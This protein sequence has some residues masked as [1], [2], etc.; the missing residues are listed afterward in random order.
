MIGL[1]TIAAA[2]GAD[3][4]LGQIA[5]VEG[6]LAPG[7][8][9]TLQIAKSPIQ[10]T[11]RPPGAPP[12]TADLSDLRLAGARLLRT[13]A[14][15]RG[16]TDLEVIPDLDATAIEVRLGNERYRFPVRPRPTTPLGLPAR[17]R[18]VTLGDS[19]P[20]TITSTTTP[21]LSVDDLD[22]YASEG[23]VVVRASD[24]P[25][26]LEVQLTPERN[27]APRVVPLVVVDHRAAR[28]PE[29]VPVVLRSRPRLT[30]NA[31]PGSAVTLGIGRRTYGPVTMPPSGTLAMR[32]DQYPGET[33]AI[34][35][36]SDDLGNTST[37]ELPLATTS[38]PSL[39]IVPG[40]HWL[41]GDAPP[42][43]HVVVLLA[44]GAPWPGTPRCET[45]RDRVAVH[46]VRPGW[47]TL[48]LPNGGDFWRS[49]QRDLRIACTVGDVTRTA[50]VGVVPGVP[51]RLA[52]QVWPEDL[53]SDFPIAELR[54]GVEDGRGERVDVP[55]LTVTAEHGEV[56]ARETGGTL[57]GEYQGDRAIEFGVDEV[58][59]TYRRPPGPGPVTALQVGFGDVPGI[60]GGPMTV[61]AR[62]LNARREPVAFVPLRLS[63]DGRTRSVM[64]QA[65][66]WASTE[67]VV[68]A[69]QRPRLIA[70]QTADVVRQALALPGE[71]GTGGPQTPDLVARQSVRIRAGR[72]AAVTVAVEPKILYAAPGSVANIVVRLEDR[73]GRPVT[74]EPVGLE[75][76][77]GRILLPVDARPDG[78]LVAQ[79]LPDPVKEA[80]E[81]QVTATTKGFRA[82]TEIE[83]V[84]RPAR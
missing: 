45:P 61:H 35:K 74:D 21:T 23:E 48:Q 77:E 47:W 33:L 66:G 10:A 60:E 57:R 55:G 9:A 31:A 42:P 38:Q 15:R 49:S 18:G 62:A 13:R 2:W 81:V 17:M 22:V 14:A 56:V 6:T 46:S 1:L 30:V 43:L 71:V 34:V 73:S 58:V 80:R 67:L 24:Q 83:V 39:A 53:R 84:P 82:S 63:A 28:H 65:D 11:T 19:V 7:R 27:S 40:G 12:G 78:T 37:S 8:I 51:E 41:P 59:A 52:L 54:A 72:I 32:V 25:G 4:Q 75:A 26:A 70:A 3:G 76:S 79:Y 16:V 44:N 69:G 5:I 20:L 29:M 64:T 36:A 50:R 68:P